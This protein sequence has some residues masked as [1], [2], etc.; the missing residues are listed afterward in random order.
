VTPK[1]GNEFVSSA[2]ARDPRLRH[3]RSIPFQHQN[4]RKEN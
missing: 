3:S 4:V 1:S 2:V